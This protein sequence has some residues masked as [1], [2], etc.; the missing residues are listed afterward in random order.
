MPFDYLQDLLKTKASFELLRVNFYCLY[1]TGLRK[2]HVTHGTRARASLRQI[3]P[4]G[5][6]PQPLQ[7][8]LRGRHQG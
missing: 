2:R 6:G 8:R 1:V 5:D 7:P 3:Q 4:L